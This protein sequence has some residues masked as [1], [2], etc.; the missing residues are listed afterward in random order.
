MLSLSQIQQRHNSCLLVLWWVSSQDFGNECLI[1]LRELERD[2]G[3]VLGRI[4]M[5]WEIDQLVMFF[6]LARF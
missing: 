1:L 3:V 2:R 5:L 4:A 6:A